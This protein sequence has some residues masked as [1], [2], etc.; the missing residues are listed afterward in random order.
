MNEL[1][2]RH[3]REQLAVRAAVLQALERVWASLDPEDLDDTFPGWAT[4]VMAITA[5]NRALSAA[6]ANRYVRQFRGA[7]R[8]GGEAPVG[9]PRELPDAALLSSLGVTGPVA[10]KSATARGVTPE[11]AA[12]AA[13]V[14]SSGAVTRHVLNAGRETILSSLAKDAA[15]GG[16]RRVTSPR[17]C[18]FCDSLDDIYPPGHG[19]FKSHDN[20]ACTAEPVYRSN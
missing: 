16:W 17:A 12:V 2:A 10:I 11:Q 15:A 13:F 7:A 1:T 4:A 8:I 18:E 9:V 19:D 14:L 3:R 6:V 5:Q 20:C